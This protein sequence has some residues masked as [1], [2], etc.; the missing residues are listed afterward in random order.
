MFLLLFIQICIV[1]AFLCFYFIV[2]PIFFICLL[3]I[4]Y[5]LLLHVF[6][7]LILFKRQPTKPSDLQIKEIKEELKRIKNH[8]QLNTFG[9]GSKVER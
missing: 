2:K 6:L 5:S 3:L 8:I 1:F 9:R 4:I 7:F